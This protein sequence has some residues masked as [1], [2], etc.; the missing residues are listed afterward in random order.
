MSRQCSAMVAEWKYDRGDWGGWR[1][2]LRSSRLSARSICVRGSLIEG[3]KARP[4]PP[5]P[6]LMQCHFVL[7]TL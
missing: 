7:L 4:P 2:R 6:P 1:E 3:A 5:P